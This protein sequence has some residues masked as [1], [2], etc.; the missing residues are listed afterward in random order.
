MIF[1]A[2]HFTE[3]TAL[4]IFFW[5]GYSFYFEYFKTGAKMSDEQLMGRYVELVRVKAKAHTRTRF[6]K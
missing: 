5:L 3:I 4:G 6:P 2:N 1:L